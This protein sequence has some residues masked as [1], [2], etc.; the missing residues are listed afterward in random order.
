MADKECR[1]QSDGSVCGEGWLSEWKL[2]L[3]AAIQA[4]WREEFPRSRGQSGLSL[5]AIKAAEAPP[6]PH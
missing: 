2:P 4:Q 3:L 6:S 1:V 5:L